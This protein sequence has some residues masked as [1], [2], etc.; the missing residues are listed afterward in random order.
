MKTLIFP[1][2]R[3]AGLLSGILLVCAGSSARAEDNTSSDAFPAFESYIKVSGQA[4]IMVTGN[5]NAFQTRTRE[6]SPGAAG[7]EDFHYAKDLSKATT[8]VIDGKALTGSE[9]YLLRYNVTKTNVGSIDFGYKRFRTFY[10]GVGGFFPLNSEWLPFTR[11]DLHID[12]A[13]F[14]IETNLALPDAPVVT[15]RYTNELRDGRKDSTIWGST[16]FTGLTNT[17]TQISDV[18]KIVP[19]Y[20]NVGERHE[21]LEASVTHTIKTT[22]FVV[23]LFGDRTNNADTRYVTLFPGEV[24]PV[25]GTSTNPA[26][27]NNQVL[28]AELDAMKTQTTGFNAAT[29]TAIGDK[30]TLKTGAQYSLV[31]STIGG[32]RPLITSTPTAGGTVPVTTDTYQG[33]AGGTRVKDFVGNV[34]LDYRPI[35]SLCATGA[36]KIEDEFISGASS[37][38]TLAAS[39]SPATTVTSTPR[40]AWEHVHRNTEIPE[41]DLRY[42]GIRTLALYGR[43]SQSNVN[44]ADR[45]IAAY[46]PLILPITATTANNNDRERHTD[47]TVGANWRASNLLT[48]RAEYFSKGHK[49]NS[50]GYGVNLGDYYL[51]DSQYTGY[52]ITALATP[53]ATLGFTTR[54]VSQ[55]GKMKVTGF[56][57]TYPAYNSGNTKN[58]MIGET[59]NWTPCTQ[60]YVQL[61]GNLVYNVIDTVYPTAG[62]T[63][64]TSTLP[65]FDSNKIVQNSNN[66]Y[67]TCSFLTGFVVDKETDLEFQANYYRA[68]DGNAAVAPWTVPYGVNV[69]DLSATVGLKHQFTDRMIGEAKLGYFDSKNDTTGG[70]TSYHGPVGYISVAYA[71]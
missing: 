16:D 69:R 12:R 1:I 61:D 36:W 11:Q 60:C 33:L 39:G 2:I 64:A 67:I 32:D 7:I 26:Q 18:R 50:V 28:E 37:F 22:S 62:I 13:K 21:R 40:V 47:Y 55:R 15:I 68:N 53:W 44:G 30:L 38:N 63:P 19:S 41:F 4:P 24:K 9:D 14:W 58:Y 23:T 54:F 42:T 71:L 48:L 25:S 17:G 35:P 10:D 6:A 57:P 8:M 46:N 56:L 29:E 51:L 27:W 34:S 3:R 20:I 5:K 43:V 70:F 65:A 66:N 45:D 49:D 59:I 52:K 31:H